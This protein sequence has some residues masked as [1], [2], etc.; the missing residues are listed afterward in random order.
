MLSTGQ[1]IIGLVSVTLVPGR[2]NAWQQYPAR[3]RFGTVVSTPAENS[4][5]IYPRPLRAEPSP[6]S[7]PEQDPFSALE[8]SNWGD[9]SVTS[10]YDEG[11][12]PL[13][14][15]A[16]PLLLQRAGCYIP[17]PPADS[18]HRRDFLDVATGPGYVLSA[19]MNR[20]TC[21]GVTSHTALDFSASFLATASQRIA[22][23]YP[24]AARPR[25]VSFVEGDAAS[26]PFPDRSFDVI[27]CNFG[28]L[29][30]A[31]PDGF[32]GEAFRCLRPGGRLAFSVWAAPPATEG[33][34]MVMDAVAEMG[35]PGVPLP[36]GPPFFRFSEE[37]EVR[38]SLGG[39]GFVDVDVSTVGGMVWD[40]VG[41]GED[42]YNIFLEGTAR[43]RA[44][45]LGQTEVDAA[46]IR[47][48]LCRKFEAL[49]GR[50]LR[51]PA[52]VSSGM[53]PKV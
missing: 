21:G 48:E 14:R 9:T 2:V 49:G 36:E 35:D 15:Q 1:I 28:V 16:I 10:A 32:L 4:K 24:S 23:D 25:S 53:K 18:D 33:F 6:P 20:T 7:S 12:G 34:G 29:H 43:T 3:M 41:C 31:D 22:E 11:F 30:F 40:N 39:A 42:L 19:A 45:L 50:P 51:M 17:A 5:V 8:L 46:A 47:K 52:V 44:L 26:M 27:A 38:R 13:T 37:G